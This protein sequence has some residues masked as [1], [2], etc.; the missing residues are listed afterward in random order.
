MITLI[1]AIAAA[2]C[3][4]VL[5]GY[6]FF[7]LYAQNLGTTGKQ[8]KEK[9]IKE[10]EA[11]AKEL[12]LEVKNEAYKAREKLKKE[13]E[14]MREEFRAIQQRLVKREESMD[15]KTE[16]LELIKNRLE[17]KVGL[18]KVQQEEVE[19]LRELSKLEL[20]KVAGL[21]KEEAREVLLNKVEEE[22]KEDL[23]KKI[24]KTEEILKEEGDEK[25]RKIITLA[26]QRY[27]AEVAT[28]STSTIV[29]LPNDEMKG[30]IIGREGRNINTFEQLTGIDVIVDDTPGSI[31]ISGFDLLRRYIAK[32]TLKKLVE[33]GRIHPARIEDIYEKV[34]KETNKLIKEFGEK[35]VLEVGVTG[36]HPDLIKLIGR[37]RFRTSY[38][39]N[40]LRHSA[41]VAFLAGML[42]SEIGADVAL[43]KKAGLLHDIGKAV[44][45]EVEGSHALIGATIVRK[46]GLSETIINAIES[47]HEEV[48]QK[49]IYGSLVQAADA[50][51]GARVGARAESLDNYIK[52]LV[53]LE[54]LANGFEGVKKTYAIQAGREVRVFVE[55]EV[56]D[57]LK[58]L[59]LS[60]NI[61]N[62]IEEEMEYP[63]EIKVTVIRETR[64]TEIAK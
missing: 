3:G 5:V 11:R 57:D 16:K 22:F 48:E 43:A 14:V 18:L 58:A 2:L 37:L 34:K 7:H 33:D 13:E 9:L 50:I 44:D 6:L 26:I 27:A 40:I 64:A 59:K 30:R 55:P 25:A 36:L 45:H 17:E 28:E 39:Q 41:E 21:S 35:V 12:E 49:N 52:R 29:E 53:D 23:I 54:N 24:K 4:G 51:S 47:H 60:R 10:G 20:E 42:A 62:K 15:E 19:K 63:G 38:G 32:E 31:L 46:F 8:L 56:I 61:A 1:I